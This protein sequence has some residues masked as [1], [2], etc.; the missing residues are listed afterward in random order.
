MTGREREGRERKE[1]REG[2]Y[3]DRIY[4]EKGE[5]KERKGEA[6]KKGGNK[7]EKRKGRRGKQIREREG[8]DG[9]RE[10]DRYEG[11]EKRTERE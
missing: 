11:K 3:V 8:K 10:K 9:G 2:E 6:W 1:Q 4:K 7:G 5:A